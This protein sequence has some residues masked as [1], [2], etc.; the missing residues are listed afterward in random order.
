MTF[1]GRLAYVIFFTYYDTLWE[2]LYDIN[3]DVV[4]KTFCV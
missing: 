1:L 3:Q 4:K 2:L